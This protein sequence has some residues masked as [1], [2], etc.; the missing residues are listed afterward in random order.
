MATPPSIRGRTDAYKSSG[1][2]P[3][4]GPGPRRA[5]TFFDAP[6]TYDT[7]YGV[8]NIVDGTSNTLLMAEVKACLPKG[9]QQDLRSL[10][11]NDGPDCHDFTAYTTPNSTIPDQVTVNG[12]LT[13]CVYPYSSNPPCNTNSP[14]FNAARSYHA[15]GVDALLAD[16]SVKFF[17]DS[18]A[19]APWRAL[20][21]MNGGE[22]ISADSY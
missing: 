19:Y 10:V 5:V 12:N 22:V 11:Y 6:F 21:T 17:K 8:Q 7:A 13:Y 4:S 20:S 18:I 16:G 9:S 15:G 2:N 14:A 1:G 3:Y